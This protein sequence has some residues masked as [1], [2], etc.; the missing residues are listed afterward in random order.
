MPSY[1]TSFTGKDTLY[2]RI[3]TNNIVSPDIGK[4][5]G[6]LAFG[7]RNPIYYNM[8]GSGLGITQEFGGSLA[9]SLAY[10]G[11]SPNRPFSG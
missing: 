6:A 9:L 11:G 4:P 1:V 5:E 3:Q 2:T 8:D 7:T 10:L